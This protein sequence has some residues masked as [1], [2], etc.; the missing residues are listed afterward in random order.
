[1]PTG[2]SLHIGINQ[3]DRGYYGQD[4][5]FLNAPIKD[6]Q[7]WHSLA[8]SLGYAQTLKLEDSQAKAKVLLA[9]LQEWAGTLQAGD[10]LL[11]TYSG[12][13]SQVLNE[14]LGVE[15]N[16]RYDQTWCLYD[17]ELL[18][19]ELFDCFQQFKTGVR[20]TVVS[21]SCHSGTI[22]RDAPLLET[23]NL[24]QA[25]EVGLEGGLDAL[26]YLRRE[27][28]QSIRAQID[29][30]QRDVIVSI[31]APYVHEPKRVVTAPSVLLM[32]ACQD[33]QVTYDGAEF[34]VFTQALKNLLDVAEIG[35][36]NAETLIKKVQ[37]QYI[38]P[39]PKLFVYG[40]L[41]P[42]HHLLSPF[43][44]EIP[45]ADKTTLHQ[46]PQLSGD[47]TGANPIQD[48]PLYAQLRLEVPVGLNLSKDERVRVIADKVEGE[49]QI[50]HLELLGTPVTETWNA[51][52]ALEAA[53]AVDN[54]EATV[55]PLFESHQEQL[56]REGR[57]QTDDYLPE[58]PPAHLQGTV[59]L[60]W[61]L[62]DDHSQLST[63]L[64]AVV[65][66]WGGT[67]KV[68]RIRIAHI[69]TGYLEGHPGL[70]PLL[71]K[72]DGR[73]LIPK[74][75]GTPPLDKPNSG[76]D[77]HGVG[78]MALLAA[79]V[80][81]ADIMVNEYAGILGGNPYAEVIPIRISEN[82]VIWNSKLFE[83]AVDHAIGLD[84]EVI[85]MSMAG[86]PSKDMAAAINKAYEAGIVIVSAAS[87][88]WYRGPMSIAPKCVLYPAAFP[89]VIAAVGA[90]YDQNPY[91]Q[92]FLLPGRF[93]ISTQYMQG[94]WGPNS[95]MHYAL[96]AYTPNVPWPLENN[97]T[98][99]RGGGGTSSA[100]PQIAAA[101]AL[102]IAYHRAELEARGYYKPEHRWKKV[103]AVRCALFKSAE[104]E[105][106]F[107]EWKK[108]Y[109]NGI[110]RA[111][112]ALQIG[113]PDDVLL[114]LS[115]EAKSSPGG[116]LEV[117]SSLFKNRPVFRSIAPPQTLH[118]AEELL[119]VMERDPE[120]FDLLSLVDD[121]DEKESASN[122]LIEHF[123]QAA[124]SKIHESP[125]TSNFL[126]SML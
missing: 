104:R 12:H 35:Q 75:A 56:T 76:Q 80:V 21:D 29:H 126:K 91:D 38:Y 46:E 83:Q 68:P 27:I 52:H 6:A 117:L 105:K 93:K 40:T 20:I 79:G 124:L 63:A 36:A 102:Y 34:G 119:N 112:E 37:N 72:V 16:E 8:Q 61:H 81:S 92:A 82:V 70:P 101:A 59:K 24:H 120:L 42:N 122:A 87:N 71:N 106:V 5:S 32:A 100:T 43:Q 51:V 67:D 22:T 19:D 13:G 88:C 66:K 54:I 7:Y 64:Q 90:M 115:P 4:L 47:T 108:Y 39:S 11:I 53:L 57:A 116:A 49:K 18:D 15:D 89:R 69:D 77:R 33:D 30:T 14:R 10:L 55:Y 111:H 84:C 26:G 95:R 110:L 97:R 9:Q 74:E 96:A 25:L 23:L 65:E 28:P 118:L 113:I 114:S 86:K 48:I 109:G 103:E 58:W 85:S 125:Y 107:P 31:Q 2:Y 121:Y 3:F 94:C 41:V 60:G 99:G 17:R 50:L 1:M 45:E 98:F 123:D 62:D 78:T 73:N 44:I